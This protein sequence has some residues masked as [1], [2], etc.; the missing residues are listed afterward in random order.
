MRLKKNP[1]V[2]PGFFIYFL[3]HRL[4]SFPFDQFL[5]HKMLNS[6]SLPTLRLRKQDRF[7][8]QE[9]SSLARSFQSPLP[10]CLA[11]TFFIWVSVNGSLLFMLTLFAQLFLIK[12]MQQ[13]HRSDFL[14]PTEIR[15]RQM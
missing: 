14:K 4:Y 8:G 5:N 1:G 12:L 6:I 9:T 13:M 7:P 10:L 3:R 2:I 15:S 11:I